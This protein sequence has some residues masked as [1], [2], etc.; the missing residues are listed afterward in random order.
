MK[1]IPYLFFVVLVVVFLFSC[2]RNPLK[3]DVS[4]MNKKV[5]FVRFEKELFSLPMKDTLQELVALHNKY[6]GFFDLYSYKIIRA[7]GID[8]EEF[9]F[10]IDQFLTDTMILNVK[11]LVEEEFSDFSPIEKE[12]ND[13]FKHYQYHFPG[14]EIP[15]VYT[16][17]SGFNQSVFTAENIVG[18]SLDKYLGRDCDYYQQ[19]STAPSYKIQN[20]YKEKIAS[21]VA[22]AWAITEFDESAKITNVLGNMIYQGKLMYFTDALLPEMNDTLKIGYSKPQLDWCKRNEAQMWLNLIENKMLYSN[23]RMDIVRYIN[24]A[25]YTNGF[26]IESPGRTGIWIGWQIVRKYMKEHPEVTVAQ[27]MKNSDYQQIL[28]DSGYFPE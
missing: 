22:Y 21:D 11:N 5:E 25:P 16:C 23:K 18:I 20:M 4:G 10:V 2:K 17:I 19:L 13:A 1:R 9:P 6:P 12:I 14:K 8:D 28:N 24:D 15:V 26:P 27:L 7:G 3:I